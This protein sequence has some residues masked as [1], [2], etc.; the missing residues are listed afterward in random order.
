[1][2]ARLLSLGGGQ[3]ALSLASRR[4]HPPPQGGQPGVCFGTGGGDLFPLF[5]PTLAE[6]RIRAQELH[7]GELA[8]QLLQAVA[9]N[10]VV[11]MTFEFNDKAVVAKTKLGRTRL[12]LGEVQVPGSELPKDLVQATGP[13]GLLKANQA[14]AIVAGRRRKD[15]SRNQHETSLVARV[16]LHRGCNRL[17]TVEAPRQRGRDGGGPVRLGF[18]DEAG[19]L[20]RG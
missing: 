3:V 14:R 2:D 10:L 5:R 8:V 18:S 12:D 15:A 16:V 19:G 17:E 20:G 13:V 6:G 9:N 1:M 4:A 11:E 7:C